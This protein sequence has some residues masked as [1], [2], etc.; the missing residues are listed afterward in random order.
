MIKITSL[1]LNGIKQRQNNRPVE[2]KQTYNSG[3]ISELSSGVVGRSMITFKGADLDP[4]IIESYFKLPEGCTPDEYQKHAAKTIE[5]GHNSL[6]TAPT[7]TGKTAIM[8][9]GRTKDEIDGMRNFYLTPLKA[10][11]N[12]KFTESQAIYGESHVGIHT[13]DIKI[14]PNATHQ[15]MTT[16]ICRNILLANRFKDSSSQLEGLSRI[17]LD[18]FHY[19]G[20]MER[21][22]AVEMIPILAP[23]NIKIV[24]ASATIGNNQKVGDWLSSVRGIPCDLTDVPPEKRHVPLEFS[25]ENVKPKKIVQSKNAHDASFKVRPVVSPCDDAYL[26]KVKELRRIDKL[27]A[28]FFILSKKEC[29]KILELFSFKGLD[30][31]SREEKQKIRDI[32]KRYE[33]EGKYLGES[34]D[35]QALVKGYAIHNSGLLPNQKKLIEEL[36]QCKPGEKPLLKVVFATETLSA[37]INMPFRTV[38]ITSTRQP[39]D[40]ATAD[41]YI[42]KEGEEVLVDG[43]KSLS[44]N[45]FH[46]MGGRAGRRGHD[47]VGYVE[48]MAT[49]PEEARKFKKLFASTPDPLQSHWVPEHSFIA[50]Y[51]KHTQKDDV[52]HE[53]FAKSF[54]AYDKDPAVVIENTKPLIKAFEDRRE[55]LTQRGFFAEDKTLTL[56]GKLLAELNGYQQIPIIDMIHDQKLAAM[57]PTELIA[58]VGSLANTNNKTD[59]GY[60]KNKKMLSSNG[61]K[62]SA[63]ELANLKKFKSENSILTWFVEEFDSYLEG[64]NAKMALDSKF[65]KIAQ[66]KEGASQMYEWAKL[67]TLN[68]NP[69]NAWKEILKGDLSATIKDEGE[70]FRKINQTNDLLKQITK[71]AQIG[72]EF[73]EKA[74]DKLYYTELSVTAK[75]AA[76]FC[77]EKL[78]CFG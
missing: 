16:E 72:A 27:P 71:I 2:F 74:N 70:L 42:N 8:N 68:E 7:G 23:K 65:Q 69:I 3:V 46:Q 21:G 61:P 9:Y 59:M 40:F 67:N 43:K 10:L 64:Y 28:M 77:L 1:N 19:L 39:T 20:D 49:S 31:N 12:Q 33:E 56:K 22:G 50:L 29:K 15:I 53:I 62:P 36:A 48:A 32:V 17:N 45:K 58:C 13:G 41:K 30:L 4:E 76:K 60:D 11:S 25:V 78:K 26:Y 35:F 51:H 52:M 24:A 5:K 44:V 54:Q 55:M 63:T 37:G 57:S 66:D 14:N 38:I 18:E 73:A 6:I 47:V 75:E 34:F